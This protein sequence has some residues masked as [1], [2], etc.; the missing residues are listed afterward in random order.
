[1]AAGQLRATATF[2]RDGFARAVGDNPEARDR[3]AKVAGAISELAD[4]IEKLSQSA[5]GSP[6]PRGDYS[7][8]FRLGTGVNESV[9]D[10]LKRAS[11]DLAAKRT[12][13]A[14]FGRSVWRELMK[15]DTPPVD[16]AVLLRRLFERVAEDRD[17]TEETY[18]SRWKANV[19]E[20]EKFVRKN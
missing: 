1:I 11:A 4:N 5:T 14:N 8:T 20:I 3:G 2:Y 7:T 19:V 15:D 16:D 10:V 9:A 13:A 17:T 18:A 12:E 6:R